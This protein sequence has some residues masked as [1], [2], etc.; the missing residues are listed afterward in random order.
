[1]HLD[2]PSVNVHRH[3]RADSATHGRS[4]VSGK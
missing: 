3:H 2:K 1:M 4:G